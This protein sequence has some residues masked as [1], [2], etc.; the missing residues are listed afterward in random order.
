MYTP[1]DRVK[2][3]EHGSGCVVVESEDLEIA[4]KDHAMVGRR[5]A[6]Q[7]FKHLSIVAGESPVRAV[8]VAICG[9]A[10]LPRGTEPPLPCTLAAPGPAT[11]NE[12]G[13]PRGSPLSG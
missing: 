7:F 12:S 4:R 9:K 10:G 8:I 2:T 11:L 5:Q 13:E 6:P 1:R 3:T